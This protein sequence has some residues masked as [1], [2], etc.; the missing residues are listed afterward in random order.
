MALVITLLAIS[1]LVAVTVQLG[2]SVNW[3]MQV[4]ANQGK[5]V[6]LDAMLLSG[7][8]LARAALWADQQEN[9]FDSDFDDWR[10]FEPDILAAI[11]NDGTLEVKV[12]DLSGLLQVNG[13]VLTE[14]EKKEQDKGQKS[15]N[16][17]NT[18]R[19]SGRNKGP[20]K[21]QEKI[22]RDLWKRFLLSGDFAVEDENA[23][24]GLVDCLVDWLDED[25]EEHE[26]GAE[27]GYYSS[28][29][30]PYVPA[31]R[32]VMFSE[33]L[34]LVKG[35][36]KKLLYGDK[37]HSGIIDYLTV[38]GQDGKININTAPALVLQALSSEMTEELAADLVDFGSEQE[39]KDLLARPDWY[40]QVSGFPGDITFDADLITT[41]SSYFLV[42]VTVRIDE[43]QRTGTG[44]IQ[45]KENSEQALLYWKVE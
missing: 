27:R 10:E 4:A 19:G 5:L 43:L 28:R 1:F 29:E 38:V 31:N 20:K 7:L 37:E 36:D 13:L 8:H 14:E 34:L 11:F 9:D 17:D 21:D 44:I 24:T 30:P 41:S 18:P 25:D 45:R 22:Q 42:T 26:N 23:A 15:G 35:W 40:R 3:Q 39:N 33:E 16:L 32:P 6:R 2:T 12:T